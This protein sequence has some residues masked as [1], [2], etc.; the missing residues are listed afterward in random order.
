MTPSH[1][2]I[3]CRA[4]LLTSILALASCVLQPPALERVHSRG[5]LVVLTR[6]SPTTYYEGTNGPTGL[7]YDL[8]KRFANYL[9][10]RLKMV[11]VSDFDVI[12]SM[13]QRGDADMA[14]AGLTITAARKQ[15]VRFGPA[16]QEIVP[17]LIYDSSTA[18]PQTFEDLSNRRLEVIT[19]SSHVERLVNFKTFFPELRWDET[20]Q[21]TSEE[22]LQRVAQHDSDFT[23]ADSNELELNRRF[24]PGLR[25]AF[26]LSTP[27]Q[28]AWAFQRGADRSL[29]DAAVNFFNEMRRTRVIDSLIERYYGH[30]EAFS[31]VGTR[32]YLAHIRTRLPP[33]RALFEQASKETGLDWQL[34]AAIGYQESKWDAHAISPTGVRGVMML[35]EDTA[36]SLGVK[37][38]TNPRDSI[39]GGARY[40]KQV[41]DS[42]PKDINEP[43]R[44]WMALAA[45]NIGTGHLQDARTLT[46]KNGGNPDLW[47][48]VK[49]SL[50]LLSKHKWFS[51]TRLGYARGYEALQLVE[52]VRSYYDILNWSGKKQDTL[53]QQG[54]P[55]VKDMPATP[56]TT[57]TRNDPSLSVL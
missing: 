22:L 21:F 14:A 48:D 6:N 31:P 2:K 29:H 3:A 26:D 19:G 17:Q 9:G 45:Y 57:P 24:N 33:L 13:I 23:I 55:G 43:V 37:D 47:I 20:N 12:L 11:P 54:E 39:L 1:I 36:A 44:T 38:R 35:T 7:E 28:L 27:Q 30:M 51:Q 42:L 8:A 46:K 50:S 41:K 18:R 53:A 52:N 10:V 56:N 15:H 4:G 16:Y 25:V 32:T 49:K 5:E 40:F 34:L